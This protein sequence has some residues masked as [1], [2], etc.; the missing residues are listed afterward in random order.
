MTKLFNVNQLADSFC[1]LGCA[2]LLSRWVFFG[3]H[4]YLTWKFPQSVPIYICPSTCPSPRPPFIWYFSLSIFRPF[5]TVHNYTYILT[6]GYI[7]FP[8]KYR[9]NCTI[10]VLSP[11]KIF[12]C[13]LLFDTTTECSYSEASIYFLCDLYSEQTYP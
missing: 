6:C 1:L 3:G 11:V 12:T 8:I 4:S 5:T 9:N 7:S 10:E 2:L 13:P